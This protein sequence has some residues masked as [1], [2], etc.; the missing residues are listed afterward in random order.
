[1]VL[2]AIHLLAMMKPSSG[3]HSIVM[4]KHRINSQ[5]VFYIF[6]FVKLLQHTFPHTNLELQLKVDLKQ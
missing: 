3:V 6:N 2:G 5:A 4:G 1:M